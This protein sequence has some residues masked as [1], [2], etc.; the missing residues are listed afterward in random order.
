MFP[1]VSGRQIEAP[2]STS[3]RT[4][5]AWPCIDAFMTGVC[6]LTPDTSTGRLLD[7]MRFSRRRTMSAWP[8]FEAAASGVPRFT[9][10]MSMTAPRA[11]SSDT[12]S[13][14]PNMQ[15]AI[16]GVNFVVVG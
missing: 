13:T 11:S 4:T 7:M 3:M 1:F 8:R 5:S 10:G 9:F 15:A 12:M 14:S 2:L 6:P 16:S